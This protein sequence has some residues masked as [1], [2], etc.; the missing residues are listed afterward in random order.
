MLEVCLS[1]M[2]VTIFVMRA[3]AGLTLHFRQKG[4]LLLHLLSPEILG[5]KPNEANC[6]SCCRILNFAHIKVSKFVT[7]IFI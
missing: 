4:C 7:S 1:G 2:F 5:V 3:G 6:Q